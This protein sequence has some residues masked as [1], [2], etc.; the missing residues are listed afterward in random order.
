MWRV[1]PMRVHRQCGEK[2]RERW[3]RLVD[4]ALSIDFVSHL[5]THPLA[6]GKPFGPS[7]CV[8]AQT[9]RRDP[10]APG[11]TNLS[12]GLQFVTTPSRISRSR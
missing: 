6:I 4:G 7:Q 12:N 2:V 10:P 1:A 9:W 11:T 5:S 3:A 8:K